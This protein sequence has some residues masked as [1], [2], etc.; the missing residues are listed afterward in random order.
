MAVNKFLLGE[1][2]WPECREVIAEGRIAVLPAGIQEQ[3]GPHL[4]LDTDVFIADEIVKRAAALV[5][6]K[7]AVVAPINHGHSPHHMDFPGTLTIDPRHMLDYVL[8]VTMSL[9]YHGFT[10]I[11]IVNGHGS[12]APILDLVARQTI[13]KS[14]GKCACA[15][16]FYM[17]S[18]EYDRT[19]RALF[20]ELADK[21]GHG[22]AIETS[23]YMGLRPELVQLGKAKDSPITDTMMLGSAHLPLRLW[24]SSFSPEGIYGWVEGSSEEK[25]KQLV[26]AAVEG[27]AKVFAQFHAKTIPAR[28]D[29]HRA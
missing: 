18:P 8:D 7:V 16:M 23:L 2:T 3:H 27:L 20:P 25:G 26:A 24:W 15:S 21:W 19:V 1:M 6:D 12:N 28:V 29:H 17:E 13:I 11:L 22:D 14:E 9:A 4:P 10:K 5:P